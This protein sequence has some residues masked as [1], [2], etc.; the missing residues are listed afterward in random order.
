MLQFNKLERVEVGG[1]KGKT[2]TTSVR[3][4][5]ADFLQAVAKFQAVTY[6]IMDVESKQ[7]DDD[8]YEFR[9]VIKVVPVG[10]ISARFG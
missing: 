8:F 6:D 4:I 1:T 5:Y 7:F 2:L 3:Q 10:C 9:C